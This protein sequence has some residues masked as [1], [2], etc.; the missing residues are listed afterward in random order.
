[1][2]AS[3]TDAK[4]NGP[5]VPPAKMGQGKR[6][7]RLPS[8]ADFTSTNGVSGTGASIDVGVR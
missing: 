3:L 1:M 4:A 6:L 2:D 7:L 5:R 8:T